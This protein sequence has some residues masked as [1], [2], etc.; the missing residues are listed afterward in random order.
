[1]HRSLLEFTYSD[2]RGAVQSKVR[3][4]SKRLPSGTKFTKFDKRNGVLVFST[5]SQTHPGTG[6][7]WKQRIKLIDLPVALDIPDSKLKLI[8][9]VRLAV[10]GDLKVEC[11]CPAFL[12]WGYRYIM[13]QLDSVVGRKEKRLPKIRNPN[14]DGTVCKHLDNALYTLPFIVSNIAKELK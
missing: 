12:Y 11:N 4:K 3:A 13:T 1:M 10:Y 9:R 14:L 2:L 7:K 5:E 6:L 8:D